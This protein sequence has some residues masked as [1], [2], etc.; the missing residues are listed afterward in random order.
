LHVLS[1][2]VGS[3]VDIA[4]SPTYSD[5]SLHCKDKIVLLDKAIAEQASNGLKHVALLQEQK[6]DLSVIND[7]LLGL[8]D[9]SL[10][11]S[12]EIIASLVQ[13]VEQIPKM[14]AQQSENTLILLR[15]IENQ[16]SRIFAHIGGPS[17]IAP[18][19]AQSFQTS[20]S[21][22]NANGYAE[23]S[24]LLGS[25]TRLCQLAKQEQATKCD[26]EAQTIVDGLDALLEFASAQL[27]NRTSEAHGS[28]KRPID[29][30][31]DENNANGREL[32]RIRGLLASSD[33]IVVNQR[34]M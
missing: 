14:S 33:S 13:T 17:R 7:N 30:A 8:K 29:M 25:I 20:G 1:I 16:V 21:T 2:L 19:R 10:F 28:R 12:R 4:N 22:S 31:R 5:A 6:A 9:T 34:G 24:E 15:A 11:K 32:K 18:H 3:I 23:R 26:T 27:G